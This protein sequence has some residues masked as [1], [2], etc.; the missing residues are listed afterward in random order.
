ML[1]HKIK[2]T[3][4][5]CLIYTASSLAQT[6]K[7]ERVQSE[8]YFGFDSDVISE[9]GKIV[10][11]NMFPFDSEFYPEYISITGYTDKTGNSIYNQDLSTRRAD[12]VKKFI[13]ENHIS[14]TD[15]RITSLG[16]EQPA[17]SCDDNLNRCVKILIV[18]K[19]KEDPVSLSRCKELF[20]EEFT[21]LQNA[22]TVDLKNSSSKNLVALKDEDF[23][24]EITTDETNKFHRKVISKQAD[25]L[26]LN[27]ILFYGNSDKYYASAEP[28]LEQLAEFLLAHKEYQISISGHVNVKRKNNKQLRKVSQFDDVYDLSL[29]RADAIKKFLVEKGVSS[30]RISVI[31]KGGEEPIFKRPKTDAENAANRRIEITFIKNNAI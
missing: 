30:K 19:E 14:N 11:S 15:F 1:L 22:H 18:L 24:P 27:D 21:T 2:V 29:A 9:K 7:Y 17:N 12:S 16:E 8:I 23:K 26:R 13:E 3:V 10:I 5:F 31:G 28:E 20:P 25:T 4:F 6:L